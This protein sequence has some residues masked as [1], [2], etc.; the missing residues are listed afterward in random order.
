MKKGDKA[1]IAFAGIFILGVAIATYSNINQPQKEVAEEIAE[2]EPIEVE[3]DSEEDISEDIDE[4]DGKV[5]TVDFSTAETED[6][7][8]F[9]PDD[10]K[11]K[12]LIITFTNSGCPYCDDQALE[13]EAMKEELDFEMFYIP[14]KETNIATSN[15]L[16][17][18]GITDYQ[19]IIDRGNVLLDDLGVKSI[20]TSLIRRK[21]EDSFSVV[22]GLLKKDIEADGDRLL[23]DY[24]D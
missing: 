13:F 9:D 5:L 11:D 24:I 18:I 8:V 1:L 17:A 3:V 12:N 10:Y 4:L 7:D 23:K 14:T 15:V 2:N 22:V 21:G 20:P 19:L 16:D 6:G